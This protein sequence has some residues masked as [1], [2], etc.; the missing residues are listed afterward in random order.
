M[1]DLNNGLKLSWKK[2]WKKYRVE[3]FLVSAAL[4]IAVVSGLIYLTTL[5]NSQTLLELDT[6][7]STAA[8]AEYKIYVDLAG[9]VE[10][11][12]VYELSS[13]ARLK[14][15]LKLAGGLSANAD[16]DFFSRNFNLSRLLS[17][18]EKIYIPSAF[19]VSKGIFGPAEAANLN[20]PNTGQTNSNVDLIN[21]NTAALEELDQLP[22]VGKVTAE[23]IIRGRPYQSVDQLLNNKI[24]G[25]SVFEKIK[26]LITVN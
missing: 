16:R 23:K 8:Q 11:P 2:I 4:I 26:N 24:V 18:Q 12:D 9:A 3:F 15:A 25:K 10:N 19:E 17:D 14:D 7:D 1:E 21:I 20:Q 22:G 5:Q 13:G 6:Q